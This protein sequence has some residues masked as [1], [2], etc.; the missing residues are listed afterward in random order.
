MPPPNKKNTGAPHGVLVV[1]KPQG[2]TSHDVV[3]KLRR[4]LGTRRIGHAGTLDPMATGVLVILLGEATKL[5]NVLTRASKIYEAQVSFGRSTDTL[6]AEGKVTRALNLAEDWLVPE[7]LQ[8]ALEV[9]LYREQQIPPVV[10]A[11]KIDGKR[12]HARARAGETPVMHPRE[13]H[14]H[15]LELLETL[16]HSIRV[17]LTVEKGY[18]VRSFARDLGDSLGVPAHLSELCRVQSGAFHLSE[19]LPWDL[20]AAELLAP[21]S[22][23]GAPGLLSLTEAA[24]RSLRHVQLSAAGA[25]RV[26]Q[27]KKISSADFTQEIQAP[28]H[29]V[30]Q[31]EAQ[32]PLVALFE[33]RLVALLEDPQNSGIFSVQRGFVEVP[34]TEKPS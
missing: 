32:G 18:Y 30:P 22:A 14:V 28:L 7:R 1:H 31:L 25:L 8:A 26:T 10:S 13:V 34:A 2:P 19:A 33:G 29:P 3:Q 27:G 24:C 12:A 23:P 21:A 15:G 11:I 16:S 17:R 5:S 6:D 9:E 4:V 20:P